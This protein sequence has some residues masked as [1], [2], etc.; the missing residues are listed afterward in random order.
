MSNI[1]KEIMM[2]KKLENLQ[3]LFYV[4]VVLIVGVSMF[5]LA[6]TGYNRLDFFIIFVFIG[7]LVSRLFAKEK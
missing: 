7:I 3:V 6:T 4:L 1:N 5:N 2:F